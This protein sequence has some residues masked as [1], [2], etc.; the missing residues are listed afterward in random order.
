LFPNFVDFLLKKS[1]LE[2]N[3]NIQK[4]DR[5]LERYLKYNLES[6]MFSISNRT[7]SPHTKT[8]R[9]NESKKFSI[10]EKNNN[11]NNSQS[12]RSKETSAVS[13]KREL[14]HKS[15]NLKKSNV[16]QNDFL[17]GEGKNKLDEIVAKKSKKDYNFTNSEEEEGIDS[18]HLKNVVLLKYFNDTLFSKELFS[19]DSFVLYLEKNQCDFEL[20]SFFFFD[21]KKY[22][23]FIETKRKNLSSLLANCKANRSGNITSSST[24]EREDEEEGVRKRGFSQNIQQFN[25][26]SNQWLRGRDESANIANYF[27]REIKNIIKTSN[28]NRNLLFD[29]KINLNELESHF[30]NDIGKLNQKNIS[31]ILIETTQ[32]FIISKIPLKKLYSKSF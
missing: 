32:L 15:K 31:S 28:K 22:K 29:L 16:S 19:K 2:S 7:N 26:G 5:N 9:V 17:E 20:S 24:M 18:H 12:R 3:K 13:Y 4:I 1:Y 27:S 11:L 30:D 8:N 23:K 6:F 25:R 10:N 14:S 21:M